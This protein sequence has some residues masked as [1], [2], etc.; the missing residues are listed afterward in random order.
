MLRTLSKFQLTP[1]LW[2]SY[3]ARYGA[4]THY[5]Y[6]E[7]DQRVTMDVKKGSAATSTTKYFSPQYEVTTSGSNSATTTNIYLPDGTLLATV[8]GNGSATTTSVIHTDHL[9]GTNVVSNETGSTRELVNYYPYGSPRMD[10]KSGTT[11][12]EKKYA[13]T[14]YDRA[15]SLSYMNARYQSGTE[16]RFI[17][18]DPVAK[19][20]ATIQKIPAYIMMTNQGGGTI[21]QM[22]ILSNPQLLNSYSYAGNNPVTM[23]DPSGKCIWDGCAL[24]IVAGFAVA[25]FL[26]NVNTAGAPTLDNP[27]PGMSQ[28]AKNLF[29]ASFFTPG[30][31]EKKAVSI[32][33]KGGEKV[34]GYLENHALKRMGER[35]ISFEQVQKIMTESTPFKYIH[36]G[37]E[38]I[39][40]YDEKAKV[41]IGQIKD[42]KVVTTVI[43]N[44]K[45]T[46]VN[47]LKKTVDKTK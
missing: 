13:G 8:E 30:G 26:L 3:R 10:E 17:S 23:K 4:T 42:S 37:A 5:A 29:I 44:V 27:N 24:E 12:V 45:E 33:S 43:N 22:A 40:Y 7:N 15:T 36:E 38:K 16:G 34:L 32:T 35:G 31:V 41:L 46:Y 2:N 18:Q 47:N 39:G 11:E 9:G 14:D 20:I 19:D 21:D 6:D 25:D 1:K 28:T